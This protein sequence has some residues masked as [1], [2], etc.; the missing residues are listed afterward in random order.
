[1]SRVDTEIDKR[2]DED[3]HGRGQALKGKAGVANAQLA[4]EAYEEVFATDRWKALAAAGAHPQRPLW[5]S[6]GVEEPGLPRHASTS[7][8]LI[9][10]DTVNTMPETT[11]KA[12][13][14]HGETRGDTGHRQPTPTPRRSCDDL[15]DGRRRLRRRRPGARGRGRREV[16]G[17]AGTS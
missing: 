12:Y 16:R 15:A 3:R 8:E 5:A 4:Y 13:A 9:A 1:M 17:D 6:T 10:P 11:I 7:S 2:L 14:D